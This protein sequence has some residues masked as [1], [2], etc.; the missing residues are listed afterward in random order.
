[1]KRMCVLRN[2]WRFFLCIV[3]MVI[4]AGFE[5]EA[6]AAG[7]RKPKIVIMELHGM[8]QGILDEGFE[9][10]SHFREMLMGAQNEQSYVYFPRVM[11]TM[12]AA[13]VPGITS[14]YTGLHPKHTGV[15]ATIWFDR[16]TRNVRTMISYG[17]QRINN[18]LKDNGVD[19]LFDMVGN[20][21]MRSMTAMLMV[22][23]GA[24]WS[25]K[26]GAFF[27]GNASVL[28]LLSK[29]FW[30][31]SCRYVDERTVRAFEDGHL[32]NFNKSLKGIVKYDGEAPDVMV[33]Q[34]LGADLDAHYPSSELIR[35][36]A[37]MDEI[38]KHYA[39][40]VL[41][42]L[43]GRIIKSLKDVGCY[44]NTIFLFVSEHGFTKIEA[45][46]SNAI[47]DESLRPS[48]RLAGRG[49]DNGDAEAVIMPGACTK[50][51]Y[52]RNRKSRKWMGPPRLLEDVKPAID[53]LLRN[54]DM[55][56]HMNA[57]VIRQYPGER[58]EGIEEND[59]WW[60]FEWEGYRH[61][62][63]DSR[64]FFDALKPLT[65]LAGCF[66]LK[67]YVVNGLRNQY[68]RT[69]APDIK[70]IN[71][72]GSYFENDPRKY[73]HHGS[74]YP[75]DSIVSFWVG[76]PGLG[77]VFPG[78]HVYNQDVSTRD[79]VPMVASLLGIS[80]PPGLDGEDPLHRIAAS[81]VWMIDE[82][83]TGDSPAHIRD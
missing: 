53:L 83:R 42:P 77:A 4:F 14:M 79:L 2:E 12:P 43:M 60:C 65:E 24:D 27:W 64:G 71:R 33:L 1:M 16:E 19:T 31:P 57:L 32:F 21:G 22:T 62:A 66:E 48:F 80:I 17:Q 10:L 7:E 51:I 61:G 5:S 13:S 50:E 8:K 76:G 29:G 55:T 26:S 56:D 59:Q 36:N 81:G 75:S 72:K 73:G 28:G 54:A 38:Q 3:A 25:L 34:L 63:N 44:E 68:T 37:T 30:F 70:I 82:E 39:E 6:N 40:T 45:F 67:D 35:K 15:V 74:Y 20:A 69:T 58:H 23:K 18:I 46:L 11:V 41:D 47:V 49:V 52:L 9:N 78:R